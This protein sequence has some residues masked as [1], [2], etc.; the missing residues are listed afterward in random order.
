MKDCP[1]CKLVNPDAALRCDCGYDFPSR[2][3]QRSYLTATDRKLKARAGG[4][5]LTLLYFY[6][7]IRVAALIRNGVFAAIFLI[8]ALA[9]VLIFVIV[10]RSSSPTDDPR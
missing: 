3:L 10:R 5:A 6:C 4:V 8:G 9:A 7:A 1:N 2:S